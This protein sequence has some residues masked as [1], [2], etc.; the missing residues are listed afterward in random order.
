MAY[1]LWMHTTLDRCFTDSRYDT[2]NAEAAR[3][4]EE[5]SDDCSDD[6][7]G[8]N[9]DDGN[10]E[11]NEIWGNCHEIHDLELCKPDVA[12]MKKDIYVSREVCSDCKRFQKLL[13]SKTGIFFNIFF[14]K[15]ILSKAD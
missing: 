12:S 4:D 13:H 3:N 15:P 11:D 14:I 1:F 2:D 8:E 10:A 9:E 5:Y 7:A 6:G